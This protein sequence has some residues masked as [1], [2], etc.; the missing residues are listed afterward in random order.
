ML[1]ITRRLDQKIRIGDD[2]LITVVSL[3]GGQTRLGI[4]A[5]Q[6]LLISREEVYQKLKAEGKSPV[7]KGDSEAR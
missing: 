3:S 4:E 6:N 7:R 1:V 5:P 2:I